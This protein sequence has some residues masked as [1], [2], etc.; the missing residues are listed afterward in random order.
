M[1]SPFDFLNPDG[2]AGSGS[3]FEASVTTKVSPRRPLIFTLD[4]GQDAKK[5]ADG[6]RSLNTKVIVQELD[7][8]SLSVILPPVIKVG[9]EPIDLRTIALILQSYTS[10]SN[11][12]IDG[13]FE[14]CI[15]NG[16][17]CTLNNIGF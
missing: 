15:G 10:S 17:G 1:S 13:Q 11:L 4:P 3:G 2:Q 5:I 7:N 12:D 14:W 16:G 8:S 9:D 6:L